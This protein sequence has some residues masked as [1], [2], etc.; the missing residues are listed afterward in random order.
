[1][2]LI[3]YIKDNKDNII[4]QYRSSHDFDILQY[5]LIIYTSQGFNKEYS[6]IK[7]Y[8]YILKVK[9]IINF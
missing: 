2:L 5:Y 1:M 6:L 3:A 9:Y 7:L 8:W 4:Y